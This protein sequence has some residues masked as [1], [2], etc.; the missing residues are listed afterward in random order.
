M[1]AQEF[2]TQIFKTP[3]QWGSGLLYRIEKQKGGG[4]TLCSMP[5]FARWIQEVTGIKNPVGLAVDE[6][7]QIYFIDAETCRLYRYERLSN[8]SKS[9]EKGRQT[10]LQIQ[11]EVKFLAAKPIVG[12]PLDSETQRLEQIFC[13]GGCGSDP[14]KFINPKRIIMDKYTLWVLDT[15]YFNI[16]PEFENDLN[17]GTISE[18]LKDIFKTKGFPISEKAKVTK[19]KEDKWVIV[20]GE[21]IYIVKKEDG[22]LNIYD[23]GNCRIQ[24]FSRENYQIKYIINKY[25]KDDTEYYIEEPVDIALDN[26]R[27]LYVLDKQLKQIYKYDNYGQYLNSFGEPYLKEPVGLAIGRE[28]NLYIIDRKCTGFL[29]FAELDAKFEDDLNKD[30]ISEELKKEFKTKGFLLSKNAIIRQEKADKWRI[31]DREKIYIVKKKDGKLNIYTGSIGD[32]SK[33]FKPSII[34]IDTKGNIFVVDDETG[35]IFQFDPDGSYIGKIIIPDFKG[36]IQGLATDLK[37]NLYASSNKGIALLST[38]DKFTKE[39]GVYYSKTLD[40]GILN[41]QWH[42]LALEADIPPGTIIEI[43]FH[44]SDDEGLKIRIDSVLSDSGKTIQEKAS[45]LDNEIPWTEFK[46]KKAAQKRWNMLFREKTGR[47]HWLKLVLSTYEEKVRPSVT[48][49]TVFY[50]RSSY[51]RYLPAVYQED[52]GSKEFLERFL[53]IFETV[54][55]DLETEISQ[56]FKYFDADTAPQEFLAWLASWLNLAMEEE[57]PEEKKREFIQQASLLYKLKGTPDGISRFI[58]IYTE[59]T[60]IILEHSRMVKPMILSGT[61]LFSW[62]SVPGNDSN[63]LLSFLTDDLDIK[64]MENANIIKTD[65]GKTI[66][67]FTAEKTVEILLAENKEKAMLKISD[68]RTYNLHVKEENGWLN[69]YRGRGGIRLGVNS[70]LIQTP[71]RGFRLGDDS[72]LGRV[73]LRDIEE[74]SPEDPFLQLAHRFTVILDLSADE[75]TRFETGLRRIIEEEKPAHTAYNLRLGREIGM[76]MDMYVGINTRV[77]G[78][79]PIILSDT[80]AAIG[81]RIVVM[82]G[83]KGGRVERHSILEKDT[84]LI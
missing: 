22:K 68:G 18:N 24:A 10:E 5:S 27:H 43:Y 12:Q 75:L 1:T 8:N 34:S 57:W 50:P 25:I 64:S 76:G 54:F 70:I 55:Y 42:R 60:P 39:K 31:I 35:Q 66:R 20:N 53:S 33:D 16:A 56:V 71:I 72:I 32:F 13:I 84:E 58:E 81:S 19:E 4:I 41:C 52:P 9:A 11:K 48:R 67:V 59:K 73:A 37:G 23:R 49:M 7:G 17:T 65:E 14:G 3:E 80:A 15:G 69:I 61:Y 40:S 78:Y 51:L 30:I 2:K 29:I 62:V 28:N 63:K 21:K 74:Q 45:I 47:Y 82:D 6:C 83:E 79:K 38:Q 44:S 77:A 26:Q 36:Q 46:D